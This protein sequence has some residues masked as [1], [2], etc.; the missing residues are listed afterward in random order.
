[1]R[2]AVRWGMLT[3]AMIVGASA[4]AKAAPASPDPVGNEAQT[5]FEEGLARVRAGD[6]VAARVSFAQ[7]YAVLRRPR[8][9]W[10]LA[11]CEEKTGDLVDALTHFK[12][13]ARDPATVDADRANAQ[14]HADSLAT[15]TGHVDVQAPPGVT[16]TV[17][18]GPMSA[19]APLSEPLD[20][21]AGHHVIEAKLAQGAKVLAVDALAGQVSHVSFLSS[22]VPVVVASPGATALPV[23]EGP[24]GSNGPSS[25]SFLT[26]D[27]PPRQTVSTAR[28]VTVAVMGGAAVVAAALGGYFGLQSQSDA[29]TAAGLRA[30][31]GVSGC[32]PPLGAMAATCAHWNDVVSAQN[33]EAD[34][35]AGL[36]AAGGVLV[37]ASLATWFGWPRDT[38]KSAASLWVAPAVGPGVAGVGA[39]GVFEGF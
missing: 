31:Y 4:G 37:L 33:R 16:L 17:D 12:Q 26:G 32:V 5:R 21:L 36:Y 34:V 27:E 7:A 1:M 24:A 20:V 29:N 23:G 28:V 10:N 3:C 38:A 39:A 8:I 11:L 13:V 35:S 6:F 15:Q 9:L 14:L 2:P 18:G 25:G 22:D 19:V 30:K